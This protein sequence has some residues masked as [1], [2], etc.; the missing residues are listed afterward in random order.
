MPY[1]LSKPSGQTIK[2]SKMS[3]LGTFLR[4]AV[5]GVVGLGVLSWLLA[6]CAQNEK[7]DE[8]EASEEE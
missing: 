8:T 3:A 2:E 5:T 1:A 4:G 7:V 6:T